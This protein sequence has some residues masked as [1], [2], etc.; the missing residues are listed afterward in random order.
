M[1][2]AVGGFG[3]VVAVEVSD[4]TAAGVAVGGCEGAAVGLGVGVGVP[5][6]VGAGVGALTVP[7]EQA[8][9][10]SSTRAFDLTRAWDLMAQ[11]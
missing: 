4:G 7:L 6:A 1:G 3:T 2:T 8:A 5:V 10:S 9:T 11:R